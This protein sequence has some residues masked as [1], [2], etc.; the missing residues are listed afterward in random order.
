M[1]PQRCFR[2]TDVV[3]IAL[4]GIGLFGVP[5]SGCLPFGQD[6]PSRSRLAEAR[7]RTQL[8]DDDRRLVMA[9]RAVSDDP[10]TSFADGK[11]AVPARIA[12]AGRRTP[13]PEVRAWSI[14][15]IYYWRSFA[16]PRLSTE[17]QGASG[18]GQSKTSTTL[19]L[20]EGPIATLWYLG[21]PIRIDTSPGGIAKA[22][23]NLKQASS[24]GVEW[25][26]VT[27]ACRFIKDEPNV[28]DPRVRRWAES[29]LATEEPDA[30]VK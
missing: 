2:R 21:E 8:S 30:G 18:T 19:A 3:F 11:S 24:L 25:D 13:H 5:L 9:L 10:N 4:M 17:P 16:H 12:R 20:S 23:T 26:A 29:L 7:L 28:N 15:S 27:F 1:T 6:G 14:E 22:R